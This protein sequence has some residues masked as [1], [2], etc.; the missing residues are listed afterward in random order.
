MKTNYDTII[1]GAG[2]AGIQAGYYLQHLNTDYLILDKNDKAGSFFDS[3]P[4]SNSLISI[5]KMYTGSDN[6]EFNLR[7]DWNSL[8][9]D[10]N[11]TFS[12]YS[13]KFY[14]D[15]ESLVQYLNEFVSYYKLRVK[16]NTTVTKIT[17]VDNQFHLTIITNNKTKKLYC[18]KLII[19]SGLSKPNI[20][21]NIIN[22]DKHTI[23]Y[24]QFTKNFF[25]DEKNL[26]QYINKKVLILGAGNSAFEIANIL[27]SYCS[28]VIIMGRNHTPKLA[29]A[30]HYSGHLR[31]VYLPF[32]D[33]FFLKSNNGIDLVSDSKQLIIGKTDDNLFE[34]QKECKCCNYGENYSGFYQ[35]INC[36][37]WKCDLEFFDDSIK[38]LHNKFP[39]LN[40]KYE[41]IN[42]PNVYFI[43]SLMHFFDREVSSGGFIHGFRYLIDAFIK[44]NYQNHSFTK[45][46]YD[47]KRQLLDNIMKRV[48]TSSGL[49]QMFGE[50]GDVFYK[51]DN[52][53][54]YIEQVPL[55]YIF[56]KFNT[57]NL[58]NT[59]IFI[60]TLEYNKEYETDL[61]N[62]GKNTSSIG[63]E[64]KS[65][66]LH[67]VVRVFNNV[68]GQIN[69]LND[70]L[71]ITDN[72]YDKFEFLE[73]VHHFEENL[74]VNFT[75][76]QKYES[77]L[78]RILS[79]FHI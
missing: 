78:N 51:D 64:N 35:I 45:I 33:T 22:A 36:T 76:K 44:I 63:N 77:K 54:Y 52:K 30:T 75:D 73:D 28:N 20:P 49:Y 23:H 32:Y 25:L 70:E 17:K 55:T 8:L 31:S 37:G 79:S 40:S 1:V 60:L 38:P 34:L 14:P 72:G 66:L 13:S 10:F 9:N 5:N 24:S 7:H 65:Q 56:S 29:F 67:P 74:L 27:N 4:H 16:Y 61:K 2:P 12:K 3:Y 21:H 58:P 62:L 48:N 15:R 42:I 46:E 57:L 68:A 41:S 26:E 71:F 50:L 53:I 39:I 11:I 59:H 43:G 19:A 47:N 69:N 18:K 6:P